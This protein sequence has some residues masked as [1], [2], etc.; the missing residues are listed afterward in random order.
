MVKKGR[1]LPVC[2]S[3]CV[4]R[5]MGQEGVF[6]SWE[7]MLGGRGSEGRDRLEAL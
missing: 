1:A 3:V 6:W 4:P 7:S 2:V 5:G